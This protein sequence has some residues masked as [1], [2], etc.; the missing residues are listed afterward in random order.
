M[1]WNHRKSENRNRYVKYLNKL[2]MDQVN[3]LLE[4]LQPENEHKYV[5]ITGHWLI[6][7][8][9]M[10]GDVFISVEGK[11]EFNW[12]YNECHQI[13]TN[14]RDRILNTLLGIKNTQDKNG[15]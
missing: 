3:E 9:F 10:V 2:P 11:E 4:K 7:W 8:G 13:K 12:F 14:K 1:R 5:Y 15:K 6:T